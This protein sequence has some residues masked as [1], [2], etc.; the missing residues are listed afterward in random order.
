MIPLD[1]KPTRALISRWMKATAIGVI[2]LL[3][4]A[5]NVAGQNESASRLDYPTTA[6]NFGAQTLAEASARQEPGRFVQI[7]EQQKY[8]IVTGGELTT[9]EQQQPPPLATAVS[10]KLAAI[11]L[12]EATSNAVGRCELGNETHSV[13]DKWNPDL[14]PHGIQVC[15]LCECIAHP[16]RGSALRE[17]RLTCRRIAKDCPKIDT[18]PMGE[19]PV[20][21]SGQCCKSCPSHNILGEGP[22][23]PSPATSTTPSHP[24]DWDGQNSTRATVDN[25]NAEHVK[26]ISSSGGGNSSTL[27][28]TNYQRANKAKIGGLRPNNKELNTKD[29]KLAFKSLESQS[30]FLSMTEP[31]NKG[32]GET[33]DGGDAPNEQSAAS[34]CKLGNATYAIGDTWSPNLPPFGLQVC[35]LCECVARLRKSCYE[36]KVTCRRIANEC[37]VIESCPDGKEPVTAPG[38]CCKSCPSSA[39]AASTSS[40]TEMVNIANVSEAILSAASFDT[41]K[42]PEESSPAATSGSVGTTDSKDGE[43]TT[44]PTE[45]Q[46]S[47]RDLPLCKRDGSDSVGNISKRSRGS[48]NK[49]KS[50]KAGS[51]KKNNL[52]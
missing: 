30:K 14:P 29:S 49:K 44:R 1:S 38:K 40:T 39:L 28:A 17:P 5:Q 8:Q 48:I 22:V 11:A 25:A 32:P 9:V 31:N 18:C 43:L 6:T 33:T 15:V 41:S 7:N 37:P 35:V 10:T 24:I 26:P 50:R 47:F 51:K 45:T 36:A 3:T 13:G 20:A 4:L 27:P 34:I 16:H 21:P 46:F 23:G 42:L 19:K 52:Q 2:L 12:K